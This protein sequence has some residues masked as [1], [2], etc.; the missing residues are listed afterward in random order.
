[1]RFA[2]FMIA[3][4][5]V[6]A[7][8]VPADA[9]ETGWRVRGFGT[10]LNPDTSKTVVNDDGD[11]ILFEAEHGFGGGGSVEYRFHRFLG[12]D[13]GFVVAGPEM[14]LSADVPELGP[15]SLSDSLTTAVFTGDALVHLTPTSPF[16]DLYVGGGVAA[17]APGDLSYDV[18]GI[19]RLSIR[20][21]NYVTWSVRAGL[22]IALGADSPWAVSLGARYIPGDVEL[23]QLG[24]HVEDD[25]EEFGFNIWSFT[26]GVAYRF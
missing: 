3:L 1:M 6:V 7:L 16:V 10:L 2:G 23:R 15:L 26:A 11:D 9:G 14:T 18:L 8:S 4:V 21:E 19:Q 25:S 22:D 20:A 13:A 12:V 5:S 24:V 17:V